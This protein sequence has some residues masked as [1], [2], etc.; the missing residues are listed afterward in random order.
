MRRPGIPVDLSALCVKLLKSDPKD[1]PSYAEIIAVLRHGAAVDDTPAAAVKNPTEHH[2][3]GREDELARLRDALAQVRAAGAVV[4]LVRGRSGSGKSCLIEHF[5]TQG[6]GQQDEVVLRGRCFE[7]ESVPFKAVDSLIDSLARHL[8]SRPADQVERLLPRD[9]GTLSRMFPVLLRVESIAEQA[10]SQ[11]LPPD[12]LELRRRAFGALRELLAQLGKAGPL[13]LW[14]DDVQW[15]DLDT[16]EL[17][18]EILRGP[19]PPR[20]L[21]IASCRSEVGQRN[22]CIALLSGP[23]I[24]IQRWCFCDDDRGRPSGRHRCGTP[25]GDPARRD[26]RA[27]SAQTALIVRESSGNPYLITEI[28]RHVQASSQDRDAGD[29][30]EQGISVQQILWAHPAAAGRSE[31][32]AGRGRRRRPAVVAAVRLLG[33]P[34]GYQ[35]PVGPRPAS[36]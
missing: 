35:G 27:C 31:E 3:V 24:A 28:A 1:R 7:Q 9:I 5:L 11:V 12:P 15:G 26:R 14:I 33:Q 13:V 23:E 22:P 32:P 4:A 8:I 10:E 17:L 19:E 16:A 29:K 25:G 18:S 20:L 30:V 6:L 2:F 21:L 36:E 34:P